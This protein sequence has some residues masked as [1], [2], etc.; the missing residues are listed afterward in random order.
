[1]TNGSFSHSRSLAHKLV[2]DVAREHFDVAVVGA[3]QAGLAAGYHIA[4]RGLKL[5]ILE[6]N[7]H[8]GDSW[9]N[10]WG[11]LRLFTPARIDGLPGMPFPA[12]A[13]A[14]PTKDEMADYLKAYVDR[15]H[16]PVRTGIAVAGMDYVDGRYVL[17][18]GATVL[19]ADQVV[20]ATGANQTPLIPGFASALDPAVNQVDASQYR[21]P[22]Q[23][24]AGA[25]LVVGA[26]NSGAEIALEAARAH[27]TWLSGR[28]TGFGSPAVF[29]R[30]AWWLANHIL[31]NNTPMGRRFAARAAAHGAPLL[32]LK[33]K[34]FAV[35]GVERVGR[36]S[37]VE[38]GMPKLEDGT[39]REVT[40]V[41]W[42]TGFGQDFGWIRLP[43]FDEG[44]RPRHERGVIAS[45]PGL[46]FV[47]LPFL[48]GVTSALVGGAGR[49]AEYVAGRVAT[50]AHQ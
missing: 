15:F 50:L 33:P 17:T 9:R 13:N 4:E 42:C 24:K 38:R 21:D 1:M 39:V 40:N 26:G 37:G 35:A 2:A 44:G 6:A 22:S 28:S 36:T 11:S 16:L 14:L 45:Q 47:G 3:G 19:E 43:V 30:P 10:R 7:S 41:V 31:T 46:Y 5:V 18:A 49:D 27:R 20:I 8:I 12:P 25:V 23:L 48:Y 32:R 29:S 34:D